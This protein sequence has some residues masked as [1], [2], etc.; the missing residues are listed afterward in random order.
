MEIELLA[1]ANQSDTT[2][3]N[4]AGNNLGNNIQANNGNNILLGGASSDTLWGLDGNDTLNGGDGSDLLI[5]GAGN[6]DYLFTNVLGP[7]NIDLVRGFVSGS[8]R[9]LI[10][11]A[12]FTGL[13]LGAL[14]ANAFQLGTTA[15]DAD[16][17]ILYD[18]VTGFLRF[19][20]DG[21]G[22]GAALLFARLEGAPVIAAT[23]IVVI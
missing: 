9:V 22:A 18:P 14:S 11:D 13:G 2:A 17:R 4:L 16:D 6:D 20:A 12:I 23:D 21:N 1:T 3:I 7:A 19:D 8:D 10:D 15:L 5:G